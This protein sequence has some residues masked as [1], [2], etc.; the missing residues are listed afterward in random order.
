MFIRKLKES[1]DKKTAEHNRVFK[2]NTS[3][4]SYGQETIY[5]MKT[6]VAPFDLPLLQNEI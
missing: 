3:V 4:K 1:L 5:D 6:F 2:L